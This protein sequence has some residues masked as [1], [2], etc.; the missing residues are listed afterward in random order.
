[1]ARILVVSEFEK[2]SIHSS[3]PNWVRTGRQ[4]QRGKWI[5]RHNHADK[6]KALVPNKLFSQLVEFSPD[7]KLLAKGFEVDVVLDVFDNGLCPF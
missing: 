1:M 6:E 5:Y 3:L 2:V 7:G 4:I